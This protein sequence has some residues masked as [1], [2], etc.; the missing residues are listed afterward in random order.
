MRVY[1]PVESFEFSFDERKTAKIVK[2]YFAR[3]IE[4]GSHLGEVKFFHMNET[5]LR[6]GE[7]N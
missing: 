7:V 6:Y 3:D 5:P 2:S 1:I 4:V